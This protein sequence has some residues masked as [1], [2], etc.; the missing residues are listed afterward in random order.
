MSV[1]TII[2]LPH[3][4]LTGT[5]LPSLGEERGRGH[6]FEHQ[7][8]FC[9]IFYPQKRYRVNTLGV[10]S[11][12]PKLSIDGF[13]LSTK[14]LDNINYIFVYLLIFTAQLYNRSLFPIPPNPL[15]FFPQNAL[16]M[17]ELKNAA[18]GLV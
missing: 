10:D 7:H 13:S 1:T 15:P 9:M 17:M 18:K 4:A 6:Y 14:Y 11:L 3:P 16:I 2:F 12:P 5:P 8:V